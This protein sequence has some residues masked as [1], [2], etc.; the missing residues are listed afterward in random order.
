[1]R[2]TFSAAVATVGDGIAYFFAIVVL[3]T[4]YE[5]VMR[6]VFSSP[7]TWVHELS[8]A[9]CAVAF[10]FGGPYAAQRDAH[11]RIS[12]VYDRAGPRLRTACTLLTVLSGAI[13]LGGLVYA[14]TVRAIETGWKFEDG[15]WAP[16]RTG[17][18]WDVPIPPFMNGAIGLCCLAFLIL[19]FIRARA[20]NRRSSA[21]SGG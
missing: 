7:T 8:I 19:L 18:T 2:S 13:Y 3:I 21:D 6:Y 9:L 17:R 5:V 4:T 20:S 12:A 1:M 11:L 16:E 14:F 15:H 10:A